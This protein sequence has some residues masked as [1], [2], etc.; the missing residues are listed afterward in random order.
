MLQWDEKYALGILSIDEQHKKWISLMNQ[1][2]AVAASNQDKIGRTLEALSKLEGYTEFHFEYEER[3]FAEFNYLDKQNH[4]QQHH[5]FKTKIDKF[6]KDAAANNLP[7]VTTL[8]IEMKKWLIQ[9]ICDEDRKY[10][11]LFKLKGVI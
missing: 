9:H 4:E 8:L 5:E 3:F 10:V 6:K 2:L 7:I 11:E 1:L